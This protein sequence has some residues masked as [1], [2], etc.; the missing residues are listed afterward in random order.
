MR[1]RNSVRRNRFTHLLTWALVTVL[2]VQS[3]LPSCAY[4]LETGRIQ[5]LA[6]AIA[7]YR[8]GS[9]VAIDAGVTVR[10]SDKMS[11]EGVASG[12]LSTS[13]ET[14]EEG[15]A[16]S[17]AP[18]EG[19]ATSDPAA[20]GE[21]AT[22][23]APND[24]AGADGDAGGLDDPAQ[25]E[26]TAAE[27]AAAIDGAEVLADGTDGQTGKVLLAD[28]RSIGQLDGRDYV[29]Q[30]VKEI[31]GTEYI[32]IGTEQQL[33]A[34]G[35]D[36]PVVDKVWHRSTSLGE[37]KV[38]YSGDADLASGEELA[39]KD[40]YWFE[41]VLDYGYRGASASGDLDVGRSANTGLTYSADA[42]YIIFRDIDLGSEKWTPLTFSGTM[43]GAV[44]DASSKLW[45]DDATALIATA[46]PT[47]SNVAVKHESTELDTSKYTGIGFFSTLT[48]ATDSV[49]MRTAQAQ[50]SNL[51][52]ENMVV[53]SNASEVQRDASLINALVSGLGTFLGDL[54]DIILGILGIDLDLSDLLGSLLS[55][56]NGDPSTFATGAFAGRV[57]G[58]VSIRDIE[59]EGATV[60]NATSGM[61]GGFVGYTN[62]ATQYDGLSDALGD[63]VRLLEGLLNIIPG[64][65]L[66]DLITI[67]LDNKLI[68]LDELIPT[69][70]V[71]P[72][73]SGVVVNNLNAG[74]EPVGNAI[75]DFAGA[76]AGELNATVVNDVRVTGNAVTV[77]AKS[78]AGG[79]VGLARNG[80]I[81][82]T[83]DLKSIANLNL[84]DNTPQTLVYGSQVSTDAL[85]VQALERYAGGFAGGLAAAH[86][87]CDA[88]GVDG[89]VSVS[90][91]TSHAGGFTGIATLGW[92]TDLGKSDTNESSLLSTVNS[93]LSDLLSGE[94]S[95]NAEPLLSLVGIKESTM[96]GVQVAGTT[97]EVRAG[98]G[99]YA[100]GL[101]GEGK[102]TVIAGAT[103]ADDEGDSYWERSVP[104]QLRDRLQTLGVE[105][106]A[107]QATVITGL[108]EVSTTGSYVGGIAGGLNVASGGG[109]VNSTLGLVNVISPVV[110]GV[111]LEG[112]DLQ[113]SANG[114]YA[115]GGIGAAVGVVARDDALSG[116]ASIAAA[117][118]AGGFMGTS[119]AG[120]LVSAGGGG[121]DL[122][123]LGLVSVQGLLSVGAAVQTK[124]R[125]T[126]V[127]G[128]DAG[129]EVSATAE[130]GH[131]GG[132]VALGS[133]TAIE[134][135]HVRNLAKVSASE[136]GGF[137]GGF[138]GASTVAGLA[139]VGES[140]DIASLIEADGLLGAVDYLLPTYTDVDVT[141]VGAARVQADV[142]GGF[143]GAFEAGT[144]DNTA[145]DE[146]QWF[147]IYGIDEVAGQTYAGGFGGKVTS[148]ALADA[149]GGISILGGIEGLS[150]D[151]ADLLNVLNAYVPTIEGA[152]VQSS[153][154]GLVVR[155]ERATG[156]SDGAAGGFIGYASGAQ[157]NSSD[158]SV[159][160]HTTVTD[161]DDLTAVEAPGYFDGTSSYAVSAPQYAGGY[162]GYVDIGNA[163]S[164]GKGIEALGST[165][166]VQNLLGALSVVA[167]T[168]EHSDVQGA[169]GGYA[170]LASGADD[171]GAIGYAGGFAGKVAGGQIQDA[172]SYRFSHVIAQTAAG[173]YVG[174]LV[175]GD[176]A[177]VLGDAQLGGQGGLLAGL[178][179]ADGLLSLAQ[180]FIPVVRNSETTSIPCGG[181]VRAQAAATD[182]VLRGMAG[183]YAGHNQGG[184]I[185]G[186]NNASWKTETAD[187]TAT[188]TYTG[189]QREAA[190]YRIRAVY[191]A[192]YAGG[193]TGLMESASTAE[194]GSLSALWGLV[195]VDNVLGALQAVYPTEENTAV[196]GPLR[197]LT[198]SEWNAW[199][200]AVGAEGA[201]G[202]LFGDGQDGSLPAHVE[203]D[204]EL[205]S[206]I[207]RIAYGTTVVAG[208]SSFDQGVNAAAAGCAGGYAGRMLTGTISNGRAV[209]TQLVRGM[210]AAGGFVGSAEAGG[211]AT[212]GSVSIFGLNLDAGQLLSAVNVFVPV[213][214]CSST[215]GYRQGMT[216]ESFGSTPTGDQDQHEADT[217]NGTGFAG[218]Y[219]G[220]GSG[221]Q[222]WGDADTARSG[223][224]APVS[225][226]GCIAQGLRRVRATA[227]AGGFAGKLQAGTA[228]SADAHISDGF[229][230]QLLD[231]LVGTTG[232]TNLAEVLQAT[233][234]TVRNAHVRAYDDQTGAGDEQWG[235]TVDACTIGAG[236]DAQTVYPIAAGGFAGAIEATVLGSLTTADD[237]EGV[238]GD[239][240]NLPVDPAKGVSVSGLRG[241]DGGNFA[242]GLV[243]LADVAGAAEVAR[244][245]TEGSGATILQLVGIG[246]ASVLQAFQP[247]I[248]GAQVDGV[249]DGLTVRAHEADTGGLLSA[250]RRSGNAGGFIGS[251][252]SGTVRE[253]ALTNLSAVS[254]PSYTGGFIGYTGKSGVVDAESVDAL[255]GLLGLSA[256][257]LNTFS[258]LVQNSS[259]AGIPAGYTVAS[260]G[261]ETAE[262]K[263]AYQV[264][265]GFV[266]YA[267]LAHITGCEATALKRVGSG[268][269]AGGFAGK[270]THAYL[271]ST[272]ADSPLVEAI[273]LVVSALVKALWLDELQDTGLIDINL[274]DWVLHL[275][276]EGGGSTLKAS[277][278][279]IP[280]EVTLDD[281]NEND[282]V[283]VAHVKI[284]SS[285]I[286]LSVSK[287]KNGNVTIDKDDAANIA[288][289]LIK[290]NMAVIEDSSVTGIAAGYDV[291]AGG[292]TQASDAIDADSGFAGGFMGHSDEAQLKNNEMRYADVVK[293]ATDLVAPFAGRTDYDP[294]HKLDTVDKQIAGNTYHVYRGTELAGETLSG[295]IIQQR[296]DSSVAI[297]GKLDNGDPAT[298]GTASSA[299][300]AAWARFD[301]TGHLPVAND[302]NLKDW[303]DATA[304]GASLGVWQEGGA[305][306]VLMDDRSVSDNTGVITPEPDDGQDPCA[307]TADLTITKVWDDH[308]DTLHRPESIEVT[309][310]QSYTNASGE[311]VTKAYD[312]KLPDGTPDGSGVKS[313]I[314]LSAAEASPWSNTWRH[315]VKMLPVA[316]NDGST[317][318]YFSYSVE[319][320]KLNGNAADLADYS[321]TV[322]PGE[323]GSFHIVITNR[324]PLPDTGGAGNIMLLLAGLA[325]LAMG[326]VWFE[327]RRRRQHAAALAE[328]AR[329]AGRHFA[330]RER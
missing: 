260:T 115:A 184:Q 69:G 75:G 313:P 175:P 98:E 79:F 156:A 83:L 192:E 35:S 247:C 315:V 182:T 2:A 237:P 45:S 9:A 323:D 137:A 239:S 217:V 134:G 108:T 214:K 111:Q 326:G 159:L 215:T 308:G 271:V 284:G 221:A 52:F 248:Y 206:W 212:L 50:V 228:A 208:R 73:I 76:F 322:T 230:Q 70:Y 78:Y 155:A 20:E 223:N 153:D 31:H 71:S 53:R 80:S 130:E 117:D 55:A 187:G 242:G 173:G 49:G 132:F 127:A 67:L 140:E 167:T 305:K 320:V 46:K 129:M 141:F 199:V 288:L 27:D 204:D 81:D 14:P 154:R 11:G 120:D 61:T 299:D 272:D 116:I 74:G 257:A 298:D 145:R 243:G 297:Q 282:D 254:G 319:E 262:G 168:I 28:E 321:T 112:S 166:S 174:E 176:V 310:Y 37:W 65:G 169:A 30:T 133:A 16:T 278:L 17:E 318:R 54:L 269:V 43:T 36:K 119:S 240:T 281:E 268:E 57:V 251:I 177:H 170:V 306:A 102:G 209:D 163:A 328:A 292:A 256:S 32:L 99:G 267:D 283:A 12:E 311:V 179:D 135:C 93:L 213:I 147:V 125:D 165:L 143:A 157:V 185:W 191:G 329:P 296:E 171:E 94:E 265:G 250:E 280:I 3:F 107:R 244:G 5:R 89:T 295:T 229:L 226:T 312:G 124:V 68:K 66:G 201:Y 139:D 224:A 15:S 231:F 190:A 13:A 210:R 285:T 291:F 41:G 72:T 10:T 304:A 29:G 110:Q 241:V 172:N 245:D 219:I 33:R 218:G 113:V 300:D 136:N 21:P 180:T 301:V 161:P 277:L 330:P 287:D 128:I 207:D 294:A 59:V 92:E 60:V 44:A 234:S 255:A 131:A 238:G 186:N 138:V 118:N 263:D 42:N 126:S 63:L 1:K 122:L 227:Y 325:T 85:T 183:G 286:D 197:G 109:L 88:V 4:A 25:D 121:L 158:V 47:I 149:G 232:V 293:G 58:D 105:T 181:V 123:G 95:G 34:I 101:L 249:A 38:A 151:V 62:G 266:G 152:G 164:L 6:E 225:N 22:S 90:A 273:L 194:T 264:S 142:A 235:F 160:R 289:N 114:S 216:V 8:S 19:S 203:N 23:T 275:Q 148:G 324:L 253:S 222:I 307:A 276:V 86:M 316:W 236:G 178:V 270:G 317:V 220:Y 40:D 290:A 314:T 198:A 233:M 144:V 196:Y 303:Q 211:A 189:P 274:T 18:E 91:G 77:Q 26:S 302:S 327:S 64:L 162:C 205:A 48:N 252:M 258:T 39:A 246:G 104:K 56:Q 97:V 82:G 106:P 202:S 195:E 7:T 150:I 146:A 96:L 188:G 51:R 309:L 24:G 261:D 259:V 279:G 100:A 193:F 200:D 87:A 103:D 84:W